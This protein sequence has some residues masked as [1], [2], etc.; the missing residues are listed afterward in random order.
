MI[1]E[2]IGVGTELLLGDTINTDAAHVARELA[3]LG[4]DLPH[5]QV[6][7]DNAIRLEEAL[8]LAL[9]RSDIVITTGGL[10]P[11]KDDLTK[12]TAAKVAGLDLYEDA[13]CLAALREYFGS[14][15]MSE[16]QKKQAQIP[17]GATILPNDAGTA[18]GC[19]LPCPDGKFIILLPG[20]PRELLPMLA[21]YVRPFLQNL[22][23]GI[24]YSSKIRVFGMGEGAVAQRIDDLLDGQ[25]P[26]AATYAGEDELFIRVS[27][28][29][30]TETAAK[31]KVQPLVEEIC[32][33]LRDVVY[34]IDVPSLEYVVVQE[35]VKN[36]VTLATAESC[37]GGSL[38]A[39]ITDIPGASAIFGLGLVTYA[40]E[41]KTA[42]L[43]V[44]T[45]MLAQFGAVSRQVG[46]TMAA[47]VRLLAKSDLGIGITGIAGPDGGS[48]EKPVGLVY[49]SLADANGCLTR[50]MRPE[51][52]Y[53]GRE[54]IRRHA[55]NVAL[56][57]VRRKLK[58]KLVPE[59]LEKQF[60]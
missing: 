40:N 51:G 8:R 43:D 38:A 57:M 26:T 34:G 56:D 60:K 16:N 58:S 48:P 21:K 33:R 42:L 22:G 49:I 55:V 32:Q 19:A 47:N 54:R 18:P 36:N 12:E 29:A 45:G 44:P 2:I 17:E 9:S 31:A 7:G 41:A 23:K 28:R 1:A 4:I 46:E 11:T 39:R 25:N 27:A 35:L 52:K 6:V 5:C 3:E 10:G 15:Q 59:L 53:R 13:G 50:V 14:R 30:D 24:I 20:P 37:T